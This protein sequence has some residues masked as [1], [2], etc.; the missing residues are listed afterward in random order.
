MSHLITVQGVAPDVAR[1]A[2]IAP[3]A[4]VAGDVVIGEG[5]SVWFGCVVRTELAPVRIGAQCN[6][7]DLTIVH[8]DEGVPA[9][10]GDRVTVGHRALLHG[11]TVH[12]D[13]LIGMGAVLLN[14]SVIGEGA[15]VAAGAVVR[16]GFEV[17]P[18]TLAVGVPA[19]IVEKPVPE[20]PRKNVANYRRFADWYGEELGRGTGA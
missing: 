15:V 5:T 9:T 6:L 2:F 7:Q 1:A 12:D 4:T 8:T 20:A 18:W 3:N 11:T 14:G 10:L 17:P 16:E 13:A 19:T